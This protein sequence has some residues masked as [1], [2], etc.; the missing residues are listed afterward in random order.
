MENTIY[1]WIPAIA[2]FFAQNIYFG[3]NFVPK[4]DVELITDG[5]S[6]ILVALAVIG[7]K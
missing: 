1:A 5:I 3:W 4:S 6:L 7:S 2:F